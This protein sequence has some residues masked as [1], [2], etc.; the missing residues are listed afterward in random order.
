MKERAAFAAMI[1]WSALSIVSVRLI[2]MEVAVD[3]DLKENE[4][5]STVNGSIV[6]CH[7]TAGDRLWGCD[8]CR[9]SGAADTF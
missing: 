7:E 8:L 2:Y 1:A 9:L 3:S 6:G 5:A 4:T